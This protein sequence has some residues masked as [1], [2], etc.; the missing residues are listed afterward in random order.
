MFDLPKNDPRFK[1]RCAGSDDYAGYMLA[2]HIKPKKIFFHSRLLPHETC[3]M[4]R[5]QQSREDSQMS[6]GNPSTLRVRAQQRLIRSILVPV[7]FSDCSLAGL[8][9]AVRFAKELGAHI[10][11][12]HVADLGPVM[13]TTG[14]GNYDSSIYT[15]AARNIS[16]PRKDS[17]SFQT[18]V[19]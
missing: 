3:G 19:S 10:V 6:P 11:V 18:A 8:K 5:M 16:K 13:M 2:R 7:D 4:K 17:S 9:Y 14:C 12:L 15:E 1:I